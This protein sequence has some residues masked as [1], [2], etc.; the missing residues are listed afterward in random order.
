MRRTTAT[1]T[2]NDSAPPASKTKPAAR[3]KKPAP[4]ALGPGLF[5]G[6]IEFASDGA[7]RVR[8]ADGRRV[9]AV[10]ADEVEPAFAEECLRT[11]R[12]VFVTDTERGPTVLGA[13]QTSRGL[14]R[15]ASGLVTLSAQDLRLRADR[16]IT[17]E[18][19]QAALRLEK[20]GILRAEGERMVVDMSSL[21][22]FLSALVELP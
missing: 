22:R 4:A 21:V 8:T 2:T 18:S 5:V 17:I 1:K 11:G 9:T 6:K 14:V 19:G 3:A 16:S 13:L 7:Y 15:E 12:T 10:L 20:E